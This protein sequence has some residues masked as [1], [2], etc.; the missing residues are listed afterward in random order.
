MKHPLLPKFKKGFSVA[1][2]ALC[3]VVFLSGCSTTSSQ[4]ITKSS[5]QQCYVYLSQEKA[6]QAWE[7]AGRPAFADRDHDGLVCER[8]TGTAHA[9]RSSSRRFHNGQAK[10]TSCKRQ[11]QPVAVIIDPRKYPYTAKHIE[12]ARRAG[13]AAVLHIDRSSAGEHRDHSLAG[14]PT[15]KG[16]D[17][18]EYPPAM[19]REGGTGANVKYVPSEDNRGSGGTM[20]VQLGKYCDGQS[21][22]LATNERKQ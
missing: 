9:R 18:D 22:R 19:S 20:G 15:K 8:M 13:E 3:A 2:L 16:F 14:I 5:F 1:G 10:T 7:D 21:F 12:E 11:K 4:N 6:Q 17:R